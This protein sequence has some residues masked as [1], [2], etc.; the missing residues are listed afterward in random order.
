[1]GKHHLFTVFR[2]LAIATATA[3]AAEAG[4]RPLTLAFDY[5]HEDCGFR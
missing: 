3:S 4:G 2:V 5:S 1:M